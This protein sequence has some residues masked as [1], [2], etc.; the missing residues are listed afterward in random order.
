MEEVQR[1]SWES[2]RARNEAKAKI[3]GLPKLIW[4]ELH[5]VSKDRRAQ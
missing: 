1:T 4:P 5:R 3:E 2:Q